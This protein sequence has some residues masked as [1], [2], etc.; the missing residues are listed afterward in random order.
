M[1]KLAFKVCRNTVTVQTKTLPNTPSFDGPT[2]P[3][4][5][6]LGSDSHAL[7][8]VRALADAGVRVYG[9]ESDASS[10]GLRTNRA[11]RYFQV[12]SLKA[13]SL[14]PSLLEIRQALA[15]EPELVLLALNDRQVELIGHHLA[16]LAPLYRIAW[17]AAAS[18]VLGLLP[19]SLLQRHCERRG[20]LYPRSVVL[21]DGQLP[22]CAQLASPTIVKPVRPLSSFKALLAHSPQELARRVKQHAEDLPLLVQEYIEGDDRALYFGAVVLD[23]GQVV[24]GMVGRKIASHPAGHGQTTAAETVDEPEV[25][26]LTQRFFA[27]T[28][29]SGAAS[30]ELKRCPQGRWWVIEPTVGRSDFWVEL[31]I[32]AGFNVPLME[33]Q[34][35][36]GLRPAAPA[37][38]RPCV[39]Y[40]SE[41]D[42]LAYVRLAWREQQLR[43]HGKSQLFP[44]ARHEDRAPLWRAVWRLCRRVA[45]ERWSRLQGVVAGRPRRRRQARPA[46][47]FDATE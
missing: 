45:S 38:E 4:A 28:G 34:L 37:P 26:A 27:G 13:R 33:V 22:A 17:A 18:A 43:P 8:V 25:L 16:E 3:A 30:L 19:K 14:L 40:D 32:G 10:P 35:A 29:I 1:G 36:C 12:P 24:H 11:L 20:L 46:Q 21:E 9:A 42:P 31:C 41:R 47:G 7:A 23:R 44:Y 5:L 15:H 2:G 6:V 39:W